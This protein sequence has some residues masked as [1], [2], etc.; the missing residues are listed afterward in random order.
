[1][2]LL[3]N[4]WRECHHP[5]APEP[6]GSAVENVIDDEGGHARGLQPIE[7]SEGVLTLDRP[8]SSR[9][10]SWRIVLAHS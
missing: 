5:W 9:W 1:M 6:L 4:L 10:R 7:F 3:P 2:Y 8:P